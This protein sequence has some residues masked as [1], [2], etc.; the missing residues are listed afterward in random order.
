MGEKMK[1]NKY[2]EK[3]KE[4]KLQNLLWKA[5]IYLMPNT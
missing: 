5:Y 1:K 2:L 3:K 4:W